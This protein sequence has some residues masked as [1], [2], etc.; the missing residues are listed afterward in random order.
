MTWAKYLNRELTDE[1]RS[2]IEAKKR[3]IDFCNK[4][5]GEYGS[6]DG[7]AFLIQFEGCWL[8]AGIKPCDH[9]LHFLETIDN[10][11]RERVVYSPRFK[12]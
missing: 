7:C 11:K 2:V 1:E 5:R 6:C 9:D 3:E 4:H 8:T 12:Y 10:G